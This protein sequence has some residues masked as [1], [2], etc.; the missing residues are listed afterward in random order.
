M[1]FRQI[2]NNKLEGGLNRRSANDDGVF[3]LVCGGVTV[4]TKYETLGTVVKLVQ[5]KDAD[6][7]GFNAAYD[8]N[9][10]VLVRYH[11]DEFFRLN[12]NGTLFLMVV[13]KGTTQAA[14]CT[15]TND[16]VQ[17]LA[18]H[19]D[20]GV[21][22]K[23][24]V[25]G[26]V[27]NPAGSDQVGALTI[28]SGGTGY[29]VDDAIT[30]TGG[31]GSGFAGK[32]T[33]VDGSGVIT[34][35]EITTH[36]SGYTSA[37][38]LSVTTSGGSTASITCTLGYAPTT[39]NGID[40]DVE[41]AITAGQA[42]V[43]GLIT[44]YGIYLDTLVIDGRNVSGS[45]ASIADLRE[46][47]A[48]NVAVNIAN[49][50]AMVTLDSDHVNASCQGSLLGALGVRKVSENLGSVDIA[51]K[52][53]TK[54]GQAN[55]TLTDAAVSRWEDAQLV[56][57]T[58]FSALTNTEKALLTTRGYIY[59]GKHNNYAGYFFND[60]PTCTAATSDYAYIENNRVWNKAARLI[61]TTLIP[62]VRSEF[63]VE[64]GDIK[65]SVR[66]IWKAEVENAINQMLADQEV[67][68][69]IFIVKTKAQIDEENGNTNYD[70]RNDGVKTQLSLTINGIARTITNEIGLV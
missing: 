57:G 4:A 10:Q 7:Y 18:I 69:F 5:A 64:A 49:D 2:N 21:Q 66:K 45:L 25:I 67:S 52:P 27:L 31:N 20:N 34:G 6:T 60:S 46:D 38:T 22:G 55:Y 16:F 63:L 17:K 43:D 24:K 32:V 40:V 35:V 53:V 26:T 33:S 54:Q 23:I 44:D 51:N 3:G 42:L 28:A 41:A 65:S 39:T 9:N 50:P 70:V 48:P 58:K 1:S 47:A 56:G 68:D 62:K 29:A 13:A 8:A 11:I 30:G 59:V 12:P 61:E 14:M 37:P 19:S 15:K 36:G